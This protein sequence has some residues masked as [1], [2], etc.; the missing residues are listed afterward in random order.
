MDVD[1]H[2]EGEGSVDEEEDLLQIVASLQLDTETESE[3][4]LNSLFP[5]SSL[6]AASAGDLLA[7]HDYDL[8]ATLDALFSD[9]T[10]VDTPANTLSM[11]QSPATQRQTCRHFLAGHCGRGP[12][13]WYSH[14]MSQRT[15][16]RFWIQGSC[17]KGDDCAFL[18]E[19]LKEVLK[20]WS[21]PVS[22]AAVKTSSPEHVPVVDS[23]LSFP[24]LPA[25]PPRPPVD[26]DPEPYL[27]SASV[28]EEADV[29]SSPSHKGRRKKKGRQKGIPLDIWS[30]G[31]SPPAFTDTNTPKYASAVKKPPALPDPTATAASRLP[32]PSSSKIVKVSLI[33]AILVS[34]SL[35][36]EKVNIPWLETGTAS[37]TVYSE[38]RQEAI[39]LAHARNELFNRQ[40][41]DQHHHPLINSA[42]DAF[43]AGRKAHAKSLSAQGTPATRL[44]IGHELNERMHALHRQASES[45]FR[46]RNASTTSSGDVL[47]DL[48]GLHPDEA[49]AHTRRRLKEVKS[50]RVYV[51]AGTGHHSRGRAKVLPYVFEA[52][53]G[54]YSIR[55]GTNAGSDKG[56]ILV[57]YL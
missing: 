16:C 30:S 5:S 28:E 41:T 52:L 9:E 38:F 15:V 26:T 51:I 1:K 33:R 2:P 25:A 47:V 27:P 4:F 11:H 46:K 18:H 43:L 17:A 49:V 20:S 12:S 42:R 45:I 48:H 6:S 56:G 40:V 14:D 23:P 44:T 7:A 19:G 22:A 3:S 24:S 57:V 35:W 8:M 32:T 13:C 55:E 29:S 21:A 53:R 50:G 31:P 54:E 34:Y 39:A 36:T 10:D 37:D